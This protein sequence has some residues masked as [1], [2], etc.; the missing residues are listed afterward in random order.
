[1][2]TSIQDNRFSR[3]PLCQQ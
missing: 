3:I 2:P 1:M